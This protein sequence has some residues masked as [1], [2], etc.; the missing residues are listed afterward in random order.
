MEQNYLKKVV[1]YYEQLQQTLKKRISYGDYKPGERLIEA[2]IA[3]EFAISRS[4]V[5]EA[6]RALI[7]EGLLIMVDKSQIVVYEPSLK[8]VKE[9]YECRIALE[10]TAVTLAAQR[11][12]DKQ[13]SVLEQILKDT[14]EAIK[15]EDKERIVACNVEFHECI[16][17]CSGNSRLKKLVEDLQS[18]T[19][20][21]RVLNIEGPNRAE[22]IL[23]GH[24]EIFRAIKNRDPEEASLKLTEH[25][26]EDL[27]NIIKIIEQ[28]R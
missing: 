8:D 27:E 16:I 13:L 21:Y 19:Q 10:S 20:F 12:T 7:N 15:M 2:Q 17:E 3:R 24:T 4:P 14:A 5:R 6:I 25:T 23:K 11:A 9:I 28:K 18:L 1:P 22:T 26:R